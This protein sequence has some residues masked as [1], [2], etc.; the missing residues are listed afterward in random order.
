MPQKTKKRN[1]SK[2]TR[3]VNQPTPP[4]PSPAPTPMSMPTPEPQK[5]MAPPS[6]DDWSFEIDPGD[7]PIKNVILTALEQMTGGRIRRKQKQQ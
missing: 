4:K 7:D 1:T 3:P 2:T 5:H 6:S